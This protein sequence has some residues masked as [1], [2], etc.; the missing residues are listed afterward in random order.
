MPFSVTTL[1]ANGLKSA[2]RKGLGAWLTKHQPDLL[3]LQ[4]IRGSYEAD[5]FA[6]LGYQAHWF[7]AERPGYSG[8]GIL[9]KREPDQCFR[10]MGIA[11]FDREGRWLA[12]RFGTLWA[13]S[14]YFPSG[15]SSEGRQLLK[16]RFLDAIDTPLKALR[17]GCEVL[18]LGDVNIAHQEID[19][20][21]WRSNRKDSGFLPEERRWLGGFLGRGWVDVHRRLLG[22]DT[23][24]YT[25]WSA[26]GQAYANDT[27]WRIDY[28]LATP[29]LA[30][31]ARSAWVDRSA[32]LSD[33]APLTVSYEG[34]LP[35]RAD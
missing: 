14:A 10:G 22:P 19:L 25:W 9:A 4:E 26:R 16:Y 18:L 31:Q 1:N 6:H 8:V 30:A 2:L 5:A 13:V 28:Q 32:R 33:H 15:T 35:L 24:E 34:S 7:P 29:N 23:P 17:N 21:N 11:D 3:A 20:K 12:A 27:G